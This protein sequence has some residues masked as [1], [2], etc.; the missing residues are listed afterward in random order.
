MF[1]GQRNLAQF[2]AQNIAIWFSMAFQAG[3]INSGGFLSCHRFVT[4][5]TG[6]ATHFGT[7]LA[8]GNTV[9]AFGMLSVPLFFLF[10]SMISAFF[11]DRRYIRR[12]RPLYHWMFALISFFMLVISILGES[13]FFG[14]FGDSIQLT[15]DYLLLALLCLSSGIQNAAITS[16]SGAVVRTTHLTGITT[17]LG[18]GLVRA[19]SLG[20]S[21]KVQA[22][23][24]K[25]NWMRAGIIISF[26]LGSTVS[27][28]IYLRVNYL[29]FI[30]PATISFA[31]AII[32]ARSSR[33]SH[34]SEKKY[35]VLQ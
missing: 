18:I 6:F 19:F 27:A 25:S 35:G 34:L 21:D 26:V 30:G 13:H 31:L 14:T 23:E 9:S 8:M 32:S 7:E 17:D 11:V 10:G 28:W 2:K 20:Y 22:S 5:T 4:H 33:K 24:S 29:G 16:A 3:M 15:K 12:Q 1:S